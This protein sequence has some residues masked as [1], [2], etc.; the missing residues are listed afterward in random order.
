MPGRLA[1]LSACACTGTEAAP[2]PAP[3]AP[4]LPPE[5]VVSVRAEDARVTP[6]ATTTARVIVSVA[7]GYHVQSNPPAK[8][9]LIP[10]RLVV[11]P[12]EGLAPGAPA[13]PRG[14]PY[15]FAGAGDTLLVYDGHFA[16]SVP[17]VAAA[18]AAPGARR[19]NATLRYQACDDRSCLYPRTVPVAVPVVVTAP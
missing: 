4:R 7:P 11:E 16:V 6:G 9:N 13:Y 17:L 14:K 2:A 5:A 15:R 19:L 1:L 10:V 12:G 18:D 3:V 8:P